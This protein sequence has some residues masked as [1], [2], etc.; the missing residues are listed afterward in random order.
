MQIATGKVIAGKIVVDGLA[1][2]EGAEVTV[3][4]KDGDSGFDLT[5]AEE[6]ELREAIMEAERGQTISVEE[7][8]SRLDRIG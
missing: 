4:A 5:P 8:F 1:L 7:L 3:I 2:D 6:A